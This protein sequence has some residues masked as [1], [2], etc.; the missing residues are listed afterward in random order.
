MLR[1]L[2]GTVAQMRPIWK[3]YG[4]LP[5]VDTGN[6]NVHSSDVRIFDRTGIWVSTQHPGVDLTAAN[7]EHDVLLALE[8][9]R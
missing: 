8:K 1:Y 9:R 6:A 5:A 3:A 4:V 2:V 7:L